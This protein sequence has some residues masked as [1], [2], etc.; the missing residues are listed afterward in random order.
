MESSGGCK[1]TWPPEKRHVMILAI[2]SWQGR[3]P[4]SIKL[5]CIFSLNRRIS[6][7]HE[8]KLPRYY[9]ILQR[10]FQHKGLG[11]GT[12]W[13]FVFACAKCWVGD[14][15]SPDHFA[16]NILEFWPPV[17]CHF[18]WPP[19][20][21]GNDCITCTQQCLSTTWNAQWV[22]ITTWTR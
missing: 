16:D 3:A 2:R 11:R 10:K 6:I 9:G 19:R 1:K 7:C 20:T 22:D 15:R 5:L 17:W 18:P 13:C 12:F 4:R 8:S 21:F 14:M